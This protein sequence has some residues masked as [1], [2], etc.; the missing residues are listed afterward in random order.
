M[1][2]EPLCID[3]TGEDGILHASPE[4]PGAKWIADTFLAHIA[5]KKQI[6]NEGVNFI[7]KVETEVRSKHAEKKNGGGDKHHH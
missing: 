7:T 2:F 4:Q 5:L 3:R 1:L 6:N